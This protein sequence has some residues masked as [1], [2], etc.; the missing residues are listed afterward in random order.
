LGIIDRNPLESGGKGVC[1]L[2][3]IPDRSESSTDREALPI[4]IRF[5]LLLLRIC[6]SANCLIHGHDSCPHENAQPSTKGKIRN[7]FDLRSLYSSVGLGVI[8]VNEAA[9]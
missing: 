7:V 3:G 8:A 4:A 1:G 2:T 6:D 5:C 9:V